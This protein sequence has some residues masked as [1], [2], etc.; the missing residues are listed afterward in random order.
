MASITLKN[1][2][3]LYWLYFIF[4]VLVT[5]MLTFMIYY[6]MTMA[7]IAAKKELVSQLSQIYQR[8]GVNLLVFDYNNTDQMQQVLTSINN[9]SY[10]IMNEAANT[11]TYLF[12]I[13]WRIAIAFMIAF[14]ILKVG[15]QK[16]FYSYIKEVDLFIESVTQQRF[17][18]RLNESGE[19]LMCRINSRFNKMANTI[20]GYVEGA[21]RDNISIKNTLADISH[22]IKTPLTSISL[23]NEIML[24]DPETNQDH[25]GF[26]LSIQS[27]LDRL[28]WLTDGLLKLSKLASKTI[29]FKKEKVQAFS[30]VEDLDFVLKKQLNNKKLTL[31]YSGSVDM[32]FDLDYDWTRE[33]LLNIIK[34]AVEHAQENSD[35]GVDF[36]ENT[37]FKGINVTN[38]GK[39]IEIGELSKIFD[40]FYKSK[41]NTNPESIGIGLNLSKKIIEAQAGILKV[42]NL[43]NGVCFSIIFLNEDKERK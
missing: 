33:A 25:R 19:D 43:S 3:R 40:R 9:K 6:R 5:G 42:R 12:A 14:I 10:L 27:Q 18:F 7:T 34:N 37:A 11:N 29:D 41:Q 24:E 32:F 2:K 8:E 17:D 22:Q 21:E 26:L 39:P 13:F 23:Y 28:K 4:V 30:L 16:V 15:L 35:I 36:I 20:K 31:S 1:R 38:L